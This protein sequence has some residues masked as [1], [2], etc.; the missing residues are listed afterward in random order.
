[1]KLSVVIPARN[2]EQNIGPTL[3]GLAQ[4]LAEEGIDYELL[5]VDDGSTDATSWEVA[6]R[7]TAN[8]RIR[9]IQNTGLHGFGRA[10]RCGLEAYTG[11]AVVISMA[12]ASDDPNDVVAYY[13]ILRDKADCA[14]GSR[15]IRG[16]HVE[17]FPKLKLV[18]NRIFN[19]FIR[20]LFGIAYDDTTNAFKGYRRSTLDGCRPFLSPHFNLTVEI[21]LKAIV[22]GYTYAVTPI[23]WRNRKLGQSS[24]YIQEMGSRYMYIVLNIWL[25]KMLT[26]GDYRRTESESFLP[27]IDQESSEPWGQQLPLR[28]GADG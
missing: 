24:L 10:V 20:I 12:D 25:E 17:N 23:S 8:A 6:R 26:R 5:V 19:N 22:R 18:L 3:E 13:Y 21:P 11:D 27:W 9:V 28:P 4:R 16:G 2:E 1:L 7:S 15:W 14:F